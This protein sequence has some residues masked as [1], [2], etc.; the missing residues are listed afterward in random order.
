MKFR[1]CY[2]AEVAPGLVPVL[3]V[4]RKYRSSYRNF[5]PDG[6]SLLVLGKLFWVGRKYRT[7]GRYYRSRGF[8]FLAVGEFSLYRMVVPPFGPV[9]PVLRESEPNSQISQ[10]TYLNVLSS[11]TVSRLLA[12]L[13]LSL[14]S[15]VAHPCELDSSLPLQ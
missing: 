10:G 13:L 8:S 11:P 4:N 15:I 12:T 6:F 2:R 14:S 5:R 7:L 3:P 9:L 1:F